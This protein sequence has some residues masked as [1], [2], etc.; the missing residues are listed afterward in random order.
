MAATQI[1]TS[2]RDVDA[3]QIS[4]DWP[5]NVFLLKISRNVTGSDLKEMKFL[6]GGNSLSSLKTC[7]NKT[8][9]TANALL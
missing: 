2:K 3:E 8:K 1:N 9:Y 6:C 5:L 4:E 7:L